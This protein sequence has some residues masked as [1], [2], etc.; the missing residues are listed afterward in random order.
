MSSNR[1]LTRRS[2]LRI[3]GAATGT[4]ALAACVA[5]PTPQVIEKVVKETVVV[6]KAVTAVPSDISGQV[7]M[8][9]FPM[10]SDDMTAL[11]NPLIQRFSQQYPGI[12]VNIE[13]L[14]WD[15]RRE[16]MMTAFA[17]GQAPAMAYVNTDTISLFGM[18][19]VLLPLDDIIPQADWEDVVGNLLGGLSW[20]GRHIMYPCLLIAMGEL[21]NKKLCRDVGWDPA[22][23]PYTWDDIRQLGA[24]GKPKGYYVWDA[25]VSWGWFMDFLW[26]SGGAA[27]D[28][29]VTK[30]LI[31]SDATREAMN[32]Y[33]E[34]YDNGWV[35]KE[36]ASG[37]SAESLGVNYWIDE[38]Q[39][40]S[41]WGSASL[42]TNTQT[43][44]PDLEF[45]ICPTFKNKLQVQIGGAGC[46]GVFKGTKDMN[47]ATAWLLWLIRPEQQGFYGSVTKF[48]PPRTSAWAFWAVDP[49]PRKFTEIR[50]PYL[51]MN[52]DSNYFFEEVHAIWD[53]HMQAA[54]LGK[55]SV[56]E[57]IKASAAEIQTLIDEW[58]AK[59]TG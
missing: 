5:T 48:A 20:E 55:E 13:L 30:C 7:S 29:D 24:L 57:A 16:K 22:K 12:K 38:K 23:A 11:W 51:Q 37:S 3:A 40:I 58:N 21:Y 17:A 6:E 47:S 34:L 32:F 45:D 27:F 56:D 49:M 15:G 54:I 31:D 26:Q 35:P 8:W 52:Q 9:A 4:V 36:G 42:T 25:P 59:R 28:E 41:G 46:W 39:I 14:P 18:N 10:G 44:K 43:Q 33:K 1:T 19:D 2:L 50:L 53:P